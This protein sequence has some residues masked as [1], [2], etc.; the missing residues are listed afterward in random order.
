MIWGNRVL[1][2]GRCSTKIYGS[3]AHI[4]AGFY[5]CNHRWSLIYLT[6]SGLFC[7][8]LF[9]LDY[10]LQLTLT[11]HNFRIQWTVWAVSQ[12]A[13]MNIDTISVGQ[14]VLQ[15]FTI[16]CQRRPQI[17]A[18]WSKY[19]TTQF[20]IKVFHNLFAFERLFSTFQLG[21]NES[22]GACE[23]KNLFV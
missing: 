22:N 7:P 16:S 13:H 14:N 4:T 17:K 5:W 11:S 15:D 1:T 6:T 2:R 10:I 8:T 21:R 19:T 12:Y 9:D 18:M 20:Q 23:H 3:P